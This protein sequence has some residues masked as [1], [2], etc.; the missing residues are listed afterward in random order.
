[1]KLKK[2]Q[3]VPLIMQKIQD[4]PS[5]ATTACVQLQQPVRAVHSRDVEA[6]FKGNNYA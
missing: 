3:V 2:E 6:A 5:I 4:D 1:L